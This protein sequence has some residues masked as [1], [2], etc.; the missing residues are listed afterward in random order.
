MSASERQYFDY[1][2]ELLNQD[3]EYKLWLD[4]MKQNGCKPTQPDL[5]NSTN[6]KEKAA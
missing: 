6:E 4:V 2:Q 5:T 1:C 3:Q